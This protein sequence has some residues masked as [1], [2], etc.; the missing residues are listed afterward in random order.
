MIIPNLTMVRDGTVKPCLQ[1]M[2]W[3]EPN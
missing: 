1:Q 2:N 3:T